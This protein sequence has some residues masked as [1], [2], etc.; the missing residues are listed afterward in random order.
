MQDLNDMLYFA[1][2]AERGGFAAAGRALG[3]PK[4]RLS[5]RVAELEARLGVRLLQRTTRKLSLTEVGEVF[6][7]HCTAVRD[8]ADAA[9]EAVAQVQSEARGTIRVACPVTLAHTTLGPILP[10][11]L[12]RHPQVRVD[13]RISN[14]V[15]DLVEEGMDVA[16]RVRSTLDDSGSL[17]VKQ[18]GRSRAL[19][20]ASPAQLRRQGTP[21][22]PQELERMDTVAMSAVDGRT[23][24]HLIGP[25]EASYTLVHRPRYVADDLLTLKLAV[26]DGTGMCVLPDYLCRD[27]LAAGR[28]VPVLPGWEPK[29]GFV[30]AVF[31]SRRGLVPAVRRFLDFLGENIRGE[32][33]YMPH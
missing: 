30:H 7:R 18:L 8:E 28:L 27:D 11:F 10:R 1:V 17:V 32:E 5:R 16:L 22:T 3:L 23:T 13:L 15:V 25:G 33:P 26:L 14:R 31:P 29:S 2:V 24:W 4:S 12:E 20:A 9:A 19:L 6:L 21:A